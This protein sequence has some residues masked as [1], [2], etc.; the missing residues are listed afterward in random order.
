MKRPRQKT[1]RKQSKQDVLILSV[2]HAN[3]IGAGDR[4]SEQHAHILKTYWSVP[5]YMIINRRLRIPNQVDYNRSFTP[6]PRLTKTIHRLSRVKPSILHL[7]I[8]SFDSIPLQW[9][10]PPTSQLVIMAEGK[11]YKLLQEI[12]RIDTTYCPFPIVQGSR[13]NRNIVNSRKHNI[14]SLL[15]EFCS[16]PVSN[17]LYRKISKFCKNYQ[18]LYQEVYGPPH[19][20]NK[21]F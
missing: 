9:R 20:P 3:P 4:Y 6:W 8:H 1:Q 7:D 14:P 17:N 16:K 21:Q 19:T 10:V 11:N 12:Q 18:K 5:V 15:L 13:L 2:P